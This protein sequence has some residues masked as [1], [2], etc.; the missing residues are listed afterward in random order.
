MTWYI[1]YCF[2]HYVS[3]LQ[4]DEDELYSNFKTFY[5]DVLDEF[6]SVGRVYQFKVSEIT[7]I[8]FSPPKGPVIF[9]VGYWSRRI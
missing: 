5:K 9:D 6:K 3:A 8:L 4:F 2:S 1:H 7:N